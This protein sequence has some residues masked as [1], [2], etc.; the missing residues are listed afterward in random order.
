MD[1]TMQKG[2]TGAALPRQQAK[3]RGREVCQMHNNE[4]DKGWTSKITGNPMDRKGTFTV[5]V[6]QKRRRGVVP[7]AQ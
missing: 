4:R 6:K 1:S 2:E 5:E 3:Q 7:Q